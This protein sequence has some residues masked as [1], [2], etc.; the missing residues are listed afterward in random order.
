MLLSWNGIFFLVC[1]YLHGI[2]GSSKMMV[3]G[4]WC[5]VF[6]RFDIAFC[7]RFEFEILFGLLLWM[8]SSLLSVSFNLYLS[9]SLLKCANDSFVDFP[10][11]FHG[12]RQWLK[13]D[14]FRNFKHC[15]WNE[16]PSPTT[17]LVLPIIGSCIA[18][19]GVCIISKS[20]EKDNWHRIR[21]VS[22]RFRNPQSPSH[23]V[24]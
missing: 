18:P 20:L 7:I 8:R 13:V 5:W 12:D 24:L 16:T 2:I 3:G 15:C 10:G 14:P 17:N 4:V 23:Q 19:P 22:V 1:Y 6:L 21:S 11:Q 9:I